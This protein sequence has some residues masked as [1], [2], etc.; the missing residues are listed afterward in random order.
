MRDL[1]NTLHSVQPDAASDAT[2]LHTPATRT[3]KPTIT[4][5][6]PTLYVVKVPLDRH[7]SS[8]WDRRGYH[9]ARL[10]INPLDIDHG[11]SYIASERRTFQR[12]RRIMD[13]L[14]EIDHLTK[15]FGPIVAVNNVSFEIARGEVLGFLGPNGAGK[16]TT[17]KLVTGYLRPSAGTAR[18]C[19][20]DVVAAPLEVKRRIGY[21]PE[22]APLYGDMTPARFLEFTA[23]IRRLDGRQRRAAIDATVERL[24]LKSVLHQPIE[25]LSKGFKRRVGLAQ[26]ILLD[27]D[28]LILDEPTDGLDP[29][30]KHQVRTILREMAGRKAVIVSTHI[31]EEVEAVCSRAIVIADGRIVADETPQSLAARSRGRNTAIIRVM[32]DDADPARAA[33]GALPAAIITA[34]TD[35][36]DGITLRIASGDGSDLYRQLRDALVA[37]QVFPLEL[38]RDPGRL[39]DVFREITVAANPTGGPG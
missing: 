30:Q 27:P 6:D 1:P 10:V 39:D 12:F 33:V 29:N 36:G 14:I 8:A 38:Y 19:G 16:S 7:S 15:R 4:H 31:L 11:F 3:G 35:D 18:I 5:D 20:F 37:S 28:I 22:G 24:E 2:A 21:L 32:K 17:M 9:A 13:T 25:T 26:A 23:Q 34:D